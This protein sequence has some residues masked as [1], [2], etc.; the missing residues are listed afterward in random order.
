MITHNLNQW[1]IQYFDSSDAQVMS[2][3]VK[4]HYVCLVVNVKDFVLF[5]I[6][7][8]SVRDADREMIP[9]VEIVSPS[10][11]ESLFHCDYL[12]ERLVIDWA[13]W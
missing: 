5:S 4:G 12:E 10:K 13:I 8:V 7:Q 2:T 9:P 1:S 6:V 11:F 3:F